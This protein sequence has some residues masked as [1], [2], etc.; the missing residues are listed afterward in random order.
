MAFERLER[1]HQDLHLLC[2]RN[3][4]SQI[5][6]LIF[7]GNHNKAFSGESIDS[8]RKNEKWHKPKK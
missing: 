8:D 1:D 6:V 5:I 2:V 3:L 4:N 7:P